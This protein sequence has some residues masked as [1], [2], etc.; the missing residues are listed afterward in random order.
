VYR[1]RSALCR[2][3]PRLR[4]TGLIHHRWVQRDVGSQDAPAQRYPAVDTTARSALRPVFKTSQASGCP[5]YGQAPLGHQNW[6]YWWWREY[7]PDVTRHWPAL[8]FVGCRARPFDLVP[9]SQI[10]CRVCSSD[11]GRA[12]SGRRRTVCRWDGWRR[13]TVTRPRRWGIARMFRLRRALYPHRPATSLIAGQ[14]VGR[15]RWFGRAPNFVAPR[16]CPGSPTT[17]RQ[18]CA[19]R[20]GRAP[21]WRATRRRSWTPS[22]RVSTKK[23]LAWRDLHLETVW[24][25]I[26]PALS[27]RWLRQL[28]SLRSGCEARFLRVGT[29][30]WNGSRGTGNDDRPGAIGLSTRTSR[31]PRYRCDVHVYPLLAMTAAS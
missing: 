7:W 31:R 29:D 14:P 30:G 9:T 20:H 25:A 11:S 4:S 24:R 1:I 8:W 13:W 22:E 12:T 18:A 3:P 21:G 5:K 15:Q 16:Q 19:T 10:D 2:G 27:P 17:R 26:E 28:R 6:A 23:F